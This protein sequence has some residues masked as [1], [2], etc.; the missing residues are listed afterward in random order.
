MK[1]PKKVMIKGREY[2]VVHHTNIDTFG[3]ICNDSGAFGCFKA[4]DHSIHL[5]IFEHRKHCGKDWKY[6]LL[7]TY[8]HEYGHALLYE[9]GIAFSGGVSAEMN[10][11]IVEN[12]S[13]TMA[14]LVTRKR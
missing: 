11:I 14:E 7:E 10:E 5:N 4:L 3:K 1:I 13:H 12:Y 8:F 9:V 2:K 6:T